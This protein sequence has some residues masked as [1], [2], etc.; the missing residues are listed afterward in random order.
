VVV[1][2]KPRRL[3]ARL[4]KAFELTILDTVIMDAKLVGHRGTLTIKNAA[5]FRTVG[6][7]DLADV[8]T[9]IDGTE[10]FVHHWVNFASAATSS[11]PPVGAPRT[12]ALSVTGADGGG[13]SDQRRPR[14]PHPPRFN[15][16]GD[17]S[18]DLPHAADPCR[19]HHA[20]P[21]PGGARLIVTQHARNLARIWGSGPQSVEVGLD[22]ARPRP[23][24]C[25][26]RIPPPP[27]DPDDCRRPSTRFHS[28]SSWHQSCPSQGH[29]THDSRKPEET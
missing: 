12:R 19:R 28:A 25:A 22:L 29:P 5:A 23:R 15:A 8:Q 20:G 14:A 24:R 10:D 16:G 1:G 17:P 4:G 13:P 27:P 3:R 6:D 7:G 9:V 2:S 26:I 18:R 21:D 11:P